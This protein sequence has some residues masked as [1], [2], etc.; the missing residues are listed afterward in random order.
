MFF[1]CKLLVK[2]RFCAYPLGFGS[3]IILI[4]YNIIKKI[5][6]SGLKKELK[7]TE[8]YLIR[9]AE[10]LGN[11]Y[12]RAQGHWDMP[13]LKDSKAQLESLRERFRDVHID[14]IYSSDL[15][16]A[17]KTAEALA[18][19]RALKI[20]KTEVLREL[21]MGTWESRSWPY[22]RHVDFEQTELFRTNPLAWAPEGA[23]SY[24]DA[25]LRMKGF[26]LSMAEQKPG[27]TIAAF[28]H[29]ALIRSYLCLYMGDSIDFS[30]PHGANTSVTRILVENGV[31]SVD[32]YNDDAHLISFSSAHE[33]IKQDLSDMTLSPLS[34]E[35]DEG[36]RYYSSCYRKSWVEA[37]GDTEGFWA[38]IYLINAQSRS[39][40]DPDSVL[41]PY[42][43][44]KKMGVLELMFETEKPEAGRVAL[45]YTEPEYRNSGLGRTLMGA[46]EALM[47]E[48]GLKIC[49]L[50][51]AV[52]NENA[53]GFYL[54]LD[55]EKKGVN[56]GV[57]SDLLYM[58]KEIL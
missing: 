19:P 56:P 13:L 55:Y 16:R 33:K 27:K 41:V 22:L 40:K 30:I 53:I 39:K 18:D 37:H 4:K 50:N 25:A 11:Y 36:R 9:H 21:N 24:R 28:T 10:A 15:I 45:I 54:H 2:M 47:K 32:Y 34:L 57:A 42:L 58:E 26:L 14:E 51:V 20:Q 3:F 23:E 52:T 5:I 17:V 49:S 7:L 1:N 29:G 44:G 12:R 38:G 35:N 43:N 48:R 31:I 8:I 46:A 6:F